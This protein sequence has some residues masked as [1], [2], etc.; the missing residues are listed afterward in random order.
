MFLG[1]D[2]VEVGL[3]II[4]LTLFAGILSGF[5]VAFAIGGAAVISFGVIAGMDQ[6]GW[7]VHQAIDTGS[8]EYAALIAEGVKP[9]T[10]SIFGYPDLPTLGEPV[11]AQG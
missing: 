8:A 9:T 11:F 10:I 4:F 2:G 6:M 1:L 3:I 5:P 7:L